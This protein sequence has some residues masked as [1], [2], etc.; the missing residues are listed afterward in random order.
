MS[1]NQ[2]LP[3]AGTWRSLTLPEV[4]SGVVKVS[5]YCVQAVVP[6]TAV[7]PVESI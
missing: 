7:V 1:S 2:Q 6:L 4:M 3:I 5:V